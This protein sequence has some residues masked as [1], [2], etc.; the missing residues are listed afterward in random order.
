M[1]E[2]WR[3]VLLQ[4]ILGFNARAVDV[5][6]TLGLVVVEVGRDRHGFGGALSARPAATRHPSLAW[7]CIVF[8]RWQGCSIGVD[9]NQTFLKRS[10]LIS[11]GDQFVNVGFNRSL[12]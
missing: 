9:F 11:D 3:I 1:D 7:R 2:A 12:R 8:K 5:P 10:Q 6:F 4:Q